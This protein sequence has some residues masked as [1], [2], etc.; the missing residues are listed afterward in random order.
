MAVGMGLRTA[1]AISF[2]AEDAE[3]AEILGADLDGFV[4]GI[5]AVGSADCA[6]T[7]F[8]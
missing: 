5:L 8:L 4:P 2:N 7:A 6:T 1:P 3:I